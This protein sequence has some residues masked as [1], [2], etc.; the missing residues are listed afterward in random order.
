MTTG[1]AEHN[2]PSRVMYYT[3]VDGQHID[4]MVLPTIP[5]NAYENER[6]GDVWFAKV[7]TFVDAIQ[8]NGPAPVPCEEILYN[9]AI[10]DGIYRSSKLRKEV[11]IIIPEL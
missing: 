3:D 7:R 1:F 5:F 11:E 4:S 8:T 6:P 10:C 2:Q 9:Q